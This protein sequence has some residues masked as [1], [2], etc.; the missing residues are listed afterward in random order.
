MGFTSYS[1]SSRSAR[2]E[3]AG[4]TTVTKATMDTVFTQNLKR[5][6]HESMD[7]KT[8][9]IRESRDSATHPNTLPIIF[10]LDETGSMGEIPVYLIKTGLP[11]IISK[12]IQKG[13]LDPSLLFLAIG[14]HECDKAPLQVGQFESGDE[15]LDTWLTRTYIEGNGGGNAGESYLLAWYFAALHTVTDAFEKRGQKGFLFTIGDEP[16]LNSLPKNVL[17]ELMEESK[18]QAAYSDKNLL[19]LAQE[20]WNVYH[21]HML[22]GSAGRRSLGYWQKMLG[23]NCIAVEDREDLADLMVKIIIDNIDNKHDL[24]PSSSATTSPSRE[25]EML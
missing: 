24:K 11:K 12:L 18:S 9:K 25:E 1:V 19:E 2:A 10:A 4:Y 3:T 22:E 16:S 14:D 5:K 23:Q 20:K 7:P 8:I 21:F 17:K 15:E 6:I 13:L